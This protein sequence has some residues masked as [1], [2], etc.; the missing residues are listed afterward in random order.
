MLSP[1]GIARAAAAL[2]E[3]EGDLSMRALARDLGVD[4]MALYHYYPSREALLAAVVVHVFGGLDAERVHAKRSWQ[5]RLFALADAYRA[6]AV[7]APVLVRALAEGRAPAASIAARF[8]ALFRDAIAELGASERVVLTAR[9]LLVDAVHGHA[10]AGEERGEE[11]ARFRRE[12]RMLLAGVEAMA[13]EDASA[14]SR[15]RT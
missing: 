3:R 12:M 15:R 1:E 5:T 9:D 11:A 4:P 2:V 7:R 14:G 10:L 8:D 6:L 13:R